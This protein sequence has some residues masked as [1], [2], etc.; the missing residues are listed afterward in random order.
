MFKKIIT[1]SLITAV[2]ISSATAAT[3]TGET[4]ID[5]VIKL[6][7][8][9]NINE[10]RDIV[11]NAIKISELK[12][13]LDGS[14]SKLISGKL[15]LSSINSSITLS[16]TVP[17]IFHAKMSDTFLKTN[18]FG[19]S[20]P[21]TY[22]DPSALIPI[23]YSLIYVDGLGK[24]TEIPTGIMVRNLNS[25]LIFKNAS[26]QYV[27]SEALIEIL[28]S[29]GI[30]IHNDDLNKGKL[31]LIK[32]FSASTLQQLLLIKE[33]L[34]KSNSY[35]KINS[36]AYFK[37]NVASLSTNDV[38]YVLNGDSYNIYKKDGNQIVFFGSTKID[39]IVG[40]VGAL[41]L[42]TQDIDASRTLLASNNEN[43]TVLNVTTENV[44]VQ[45]QRIDVADTQKWVYNVKTYNNAKEYASCIDLYNSNDSFAAHSGQVYEKV[46]YNGA[47]CYV[48]INT[49]KMITKQQC[50]IVPTQKLPTEITCETAVYD[51]CG[52]V[53]N[54]I[55]A[56]TARTIAMKWNPEPGA[57]SS[58]GGKCFIRKGI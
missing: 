26:G 15:L 3:T 11:N 50:Y 30:T 19:I 31:T 2:A 53:L 57:K 36:L 51:G 32:N 40:D 39:I 27:V 7:T 44:A 28:Y 41:D 16:S 4:G 43:V 35:I 5:Y 6:N 21:L 33:T 34:A 38:L 1:L 25:G 52:I 13:N 22:G 17:Q 29:N 8:L 58:I 49:G 23:E 10:T 9:E 42:L 56:V 37:E 24:A 55:G 20:L 54:N 12:I 14:G 48:D 45:Y 46:L 18:E 47:T